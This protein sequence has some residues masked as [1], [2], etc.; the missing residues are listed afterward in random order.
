MQAEINRDL[1]KLLAKLVPCP[2]D[3]IRPTHFGDHVL[4]SPRQNVG[5]GKRGLW[6]FGQWYQWCRDDS[7]PNC[8]K[9]YHQFSAA[10]RDLADTN[11]EVGDLLRARDEVAPTPKGPRVDERRRQR[12]APYPSSSSSRTRA[13]PG[14]S[15]T[16]TRRRV[17][18]SS[19]LSRPSDSSTST[20]LVA[21]TSS[22]SQ[23]FLPYS[24]THSLALNPVTTIT[25]QPQHVPAH[26]SPDGFILPLT[27]VPPKLSQ[28][29]TTDSGSSTSARSPSPDLVYPAVLDILTPIRLVIFVKDTEPPARM[30]V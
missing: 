1:S 21:N 8:P 4:T 27:M 2:H 20:T 14:T 12:P 10:R 19:P 3:A 18:F 22:P 13:A 24:Q 28:V 6:G 15:P 11:I 5:G 30:T 17:R 29:T 25:S 16:P 26:Y 23:S 9:R 7:H